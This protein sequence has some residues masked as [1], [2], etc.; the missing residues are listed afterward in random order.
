MT[1]MAAP[2]PRAGLWDVLP[3]LLSI[4]VLGT[5]GPGCASRAQDL[6]L[7][8]EALY[9]GDVESALT[10]F[11][12]VGGKDTDLLH[13]LEQGYLLHVAGRWEESN[14]AWQRAEERAEDLYTRSI[15]REAAALLTSDNAL[16]YRGQPFE[17]Q[18]IQYY[19]AL[20]YLELGSLDGALVEARKAN[21][22]ADQVYAKEEEE[23]DEDGKLGPTQH[24]NAFLDYFT[25]LLYARAGEWNDAVVSFRNSYAGYGEANVRYGVGVPATLTRDLYR[26]LLRTGQSS[27][28]ARIAEAHPEA[29]SGASESAGKTKRIVVFFESGFVPHRESVDITLPIFDDKGNSSAWL[30]VDRYGPEIYSYSSSA[31]LDHVL[32]FAFPRLE[33]VPSP[34]AHCELDVPARGALSA[35]P[36]LDLGAIAEDDFGQR[37]PRILLKTVARALVK[38]TQRKAAKKENEVLGWVIN[39]INVATEQADTRSWIFLPG[40]IDVIDVE[41][42]AGVDTVKGRFVDKFGQTVDEWTLDLSGST[43]DMEILS[44]RT[45]H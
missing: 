34:V 21:Y 39:A 40:R 18:M 17:L 2:A 13:L 24:P 15:T 37:L 9:R 43:S 27:E 5:F 25:G 44:L 1:R 8:R 38:E 16:P 28:A 35:T 3:L 31:E 4:L 36:V 14:E 33:T 20:N 19:R 11:D 30:Y 45:F 26:A 42:P 10:E 7:V 41:V 6:S 12:K 32:R 29:V 22:L 23:D